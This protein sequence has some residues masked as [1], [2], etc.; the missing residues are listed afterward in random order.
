MTHPLTKLI[1]PWF[2]VAGARRRG[3]RTAPAGVRRT[4]GCPRRR[5]RR[6][7]LPA[8]TAPPA[9]PTAPADVA[10][11]RAQCT[12]ADER[13]SRSSRRESSRSRTEGRA[14]ARRRHVAAH[15]DA[16]AKIQRNERHVIY[17]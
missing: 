3:H 1:A 8:R 14:Q 9:A 11:A 16:L 6:F 13:R 2:V 15:T 7:I 5:D 17:G 12:A 4:A 10:S